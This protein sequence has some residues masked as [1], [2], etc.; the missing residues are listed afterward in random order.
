MNNTG[1][2]QTLLP[3]AEGAGYVSPRQRLGT[4][5]YPCRNC[6]PKGQHINNGKKYTALSGRKMAILT[7]IPTALPWA[8][9]FRAF[10]AYYSPKTPLT[11]NH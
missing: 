5:A 3:R 10:S 4:G 1:L 9:I 11:I 8:D 6:A 7:R 2:K